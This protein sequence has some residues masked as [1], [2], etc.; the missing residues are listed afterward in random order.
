MCQWCVVYDHQSKYKSLVGVFLV[1]NLAVGDDGWTW[2]NSKQEEN[3]NNIYQMTEQCDPMSVGVENIYELK[4]H[5]YYGY[6][7]PRA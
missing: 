3:N 1:S 2:G 7:R 5:H 6:K 4:L